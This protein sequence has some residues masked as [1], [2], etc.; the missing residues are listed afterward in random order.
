MVGLAADTANA[1]AAEPQ[2]LDRPELPFQGTGISDG[3]DKSL[4]SDN[5]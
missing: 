4:S 3:S 5:S 2:A 1:D